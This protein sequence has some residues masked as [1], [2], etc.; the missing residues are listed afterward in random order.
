MGWD[1]VQRTSEDGKREHEKKESGTGKSAGRLKV[2]E[3]R[4]WM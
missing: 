3:A 2:E 1:A 4:S